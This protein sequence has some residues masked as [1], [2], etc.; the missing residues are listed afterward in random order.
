MCRYLWL[1][2]NNAFAAP[3][4]G[5]AF[6]GTFANQGELYFDQSTNILYGNNDAD[7][8]ADFSIMVMGV[9]SLAAADF[10]L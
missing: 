3:T 10:V 1:K 6:S 5:D 9:T 2:G 7:S 4:I 8:T